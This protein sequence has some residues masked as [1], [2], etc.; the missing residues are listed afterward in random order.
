MAAG[1]GRGQARAE[2]AGE[3]R[4]RPRIR[5][6]QDGAAA[7]ERRALQPHAQHRAAGGSGAWIQA[8]S[9][10]AEAR[11]TSSTG[12]P[13]RGWALDNDPRE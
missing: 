9:M 1:A 6:A 10:L 2:Q 13:G 12:D 5:R 11:A 8:S 4:A 3:S 7:G